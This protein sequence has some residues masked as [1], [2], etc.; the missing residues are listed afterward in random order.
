MRVVKAFSFFILFISMYDSH[1]QEFEFSKVNL[2]AGVG[3]WQFSFGPSLT[4]MGDLKVIE[5]ISVGIQAGQSYPELFIN[6]WKTTMSFILGR[7]AYHMT[8]L[9]NKNENMPKGFD[10]YI[11]LSLGVITGKTKFSNYNFKGGTEIIFRPYLG[12]E[13]NSEKNIG[14]FLELGIPVTYLGVSI[15]L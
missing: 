9:L 8:E 3:Y 4:V 1:S 12:F 14:Y 2:K 10:S 13:F 11:G 6:S 5:N 15:K 7:T